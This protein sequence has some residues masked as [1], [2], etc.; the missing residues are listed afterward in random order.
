MYFSKKM[1][2]NQAGKNQFADVVGARKAF[3]VSQNI[4]APALK[5]AGFA[6]NE[7][8][9]PRDV[10]QDFDNVTVEV[11]TSDDGDTFLND[12]LGLSVSVNIG[13]LTQQFRQASDAGRVQT[14]MSGQIGVKMDQ[15]EYT[16]DGS[17]IPVHDAGFYRNWREWNAQGSEGFDAL[18][19]D[20]R[21][22]VKSVRRHYADE[23]LD[24]HR[25]KDGNFIVVDGLSYQG[26]RN[27]SR[28]EQFNIGA[29]GL[30]FDFTSTANT[31]DEIK[32]AFISVRDAMYITNKCEMDL[33]YYI[34]R[35]M[36]SNFERK[37]STQYDARLI[38][39]ELA[40]LI[41]VASIKVSSKLTGNEFFGMPLSRDKVR[42]VTGMGINT[43]ALPRQ[44]YN[45]DYKFATWGAAGYQIRTDY[46]SNTCVIYAADMG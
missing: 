44:F 7:G 17:I 29:S 25:D 8:I 45:S 28:V 24:G 27:D 40:S 30:N 32:A 13:K 2:T 6:V 41:G 15:V 18:I 46:N 4:H 19:D 21:E 36:A 42:I 31:G 34:S 10:Y 3:E 1:I 38:N 11:M 33:T 14:S 39:Q 22:T 16:Y 35:E 43:V 12:L 26:I 23:F 9:I 5:A 20:Q 37:F